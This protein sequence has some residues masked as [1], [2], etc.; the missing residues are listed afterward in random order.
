MK[1]HL[2]YTLFLPL[3]AAFTACSEGMDSDNSPYADGMGGLRLK[4]S[5]TT[6]ITIPVITKSA[7]FSDIV[8]D[9]FYVGIL[10]ESGSV[11]KEF[12]SFTA[13]VDTGLPLALPYGKYQAI[14]SSYKKENTKVSEDPYF[15]DQ[16]E[17]IIEEKKT[18]EVSLNCKY[19]S[20]GVE[21][22]ISDQFKALLESMPNDYAYDVTV[23]NGVADWKF[24]VDQTKP[25]Y[26]L[27]ACEELVV[28]VKVRLGS[29]NDWYPER[30]YR[31]KNNGS[32]PQLGEYYIIRLDAGAEEEKYS[33][34]SIALTEKE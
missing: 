7:D 28:K 12:E 11:V 15:V 16:Q 19:K 23:S 21:L 5:T 20:L 13:L 31:I 24:S 9:D 8:V 25:G 22:A 17:F 34:K 27:D 3:F 29:S 33:L 14:S 6:N 1:K 30:T 4:N 18:T 10:D 26:F 2:L 32:S